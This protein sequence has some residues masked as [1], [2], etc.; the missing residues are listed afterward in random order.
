YQRV[1]RNAALVGLDLVGPVGLR[2]AISGLSELGAFSRRTRK[3]GIFAG[4]RGKR[5]LEQIIA[6][7]ARGR[8][9]GGLLLA[10]HSIEF[11][12]RQNSHAV[13]GRGNDVG[14]LGTRSPVGT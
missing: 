7:E 1:A 12:V 8:Q 14:A 6:H 13:L 5:L 10:A 11:Q 4:V 2:A 9:P 3:G